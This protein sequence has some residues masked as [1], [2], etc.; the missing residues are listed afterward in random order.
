[1]I[2]MNYGKYVIPKRLKQVVELQ[3]H[4]NE[5]G[6]SMHGYFLGY[7]FSYAPIDDRYLNTPLDVIPFANPGSDGVHFGFL[8]DFGQVKDL[9]DAY[10]VRVSPMDSDNPVHIVARNIED[11]ISAICFYPNAMDLL[12]MRSTHKDVLNFLDEYPMLQ[13]ET[14]QSDQEYDVHRIVYETLHLNPFENFEDY[15]NLVQQQRNMET[16]LPTIDYIGVAK[17]SDAAEGTPTNISLLN[18]ENRED[19]TLPEVK[20]FFET[21]AYEAKLAFLRDTYS[22]ALVW[23]HEDIKSFLKEQLRSMKLTAEAER[24]SYP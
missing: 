20:S 7:Y 17:K 4:L 2:E 16:I 12:D 22:R 13:T 1:M 14:I 10:I 8:T 11:F 6:K 5:I 23:D 18:L 21:A 24:I 3:K 19:I 15:F 9:H